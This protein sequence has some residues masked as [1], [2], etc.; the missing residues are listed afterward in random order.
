[1]NKGVKETFCT[2]CIHRE[3]CSKKFLYFKIV[4]ALDECCAIQGDDIV[5]I[6]SIDWITVSHP[7]CKHYA[8]GTES[9]CR[10]GLRE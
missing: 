6:S 1:M 9:V 8:L 7:V 4:E 3:V 2:K 5:L 10:N